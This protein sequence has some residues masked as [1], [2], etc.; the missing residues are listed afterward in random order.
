V[1]NG[2]NHS[3]TKMFLL[4]S[5]QQN[6]NLGG[7]NTVRRLVFCGLAAVYCLMAASPVAKVRSSDRFTLSGTAVSAAGVE[8]WPLVLGDEIV[9][10]GALRALILPT[11]EVSMSC[12]IRRS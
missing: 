10:A 4:D 3:A 6:V 5:F 8:S 2:I 7:E 9:T 11:G 1:T 12:R